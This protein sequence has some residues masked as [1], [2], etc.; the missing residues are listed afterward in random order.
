MKNCLIAL[1]T[2]ALLASVTGQLHADVVTPVDATATSSFAFPPTVLID[3]SGLDGIGAVPDQRHD[4]DENAMWIAAGGTEAQNEALEFKLPRNF[5]LTDAYLWNYNAL[6]AFGDPLNQRGI[7]A[8][9]LLVSPDL[10]SPF[11]SVG[12]FNLLIAVDPL[13]PAGEAAQTFSL[14]GA[15]NVRRVMVDINS[16][17][18]G[19]TGEFVG[20]S[21]IRFEGTPLPLGPDRT[22]NVD[23]FG[24]WTEDLNWDPGFSPVENTDHAIFGDVITAPRTVLVEQSITIKQ[25]TFANTNTYAIAGT[26]DVTLN[27][28]SGNATL[29]VAGD[30]AAGAHQFQAVVNLEANTDAAIGSGASLEFNNRLN[31]NGNTLTKTGLGTLLVSNT[32]NTG[33]GMIDCQEGTC[34]GAGRVGGGLENSGGIVSPG[35]SPGILTVGQDYTQFADGTLLIEVEGSIPGSGHDQLV[36]EQT[37]TLDGILDIDPSVG[38]QDPAVRGD[39][40]ELVV[41][42]AASVNGSFASVDYDGGVLS[43]GSNYAGDNQ[44]GD[45]GLFRI[46]EHGSSDVTVTNYLALDGDANGDLTVDGQDFLIWNINKFTGG[47]DWTTGD[48]NGDGTTDGQDFLLWNMN[49]FTSVGGGS[50]LVPEPCT[51]TLLLLTLAGAGLSTLRKPSR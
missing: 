46:L 20:L 7:D 51:L 12:S 11:V 23:A 33:G 21:E 22:W 49:K 15:T 14:T 27:P 26:G 45:D 8:F 18:E 4:N 17:H 10:E 39:I 31:L 16:S 5:D 30:A 41:L 43:E 29:T 3:G 47:T 42:T 24:D 44:N 19:P 37:A 38:Y 25:I 9:E 35:N 36:V 48:F 2:A 28:D 1:I 34:G 50:N 13:N 32:L 40:D 6:G